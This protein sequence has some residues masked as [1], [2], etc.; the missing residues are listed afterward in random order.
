MDLAAMLISGLVAGLAAGAA[1]CA[2]V[3]GGFL[4]ALHPAGARVLATFL[5]A[6]V[7]AHAVVGA[8]LGLVGGALPMSPAVRAAV[9]VVAGVVICAHAVRRLRRGPSCAAR[10]EKGTSRAAALGAATVLTPCGVTLSVELVAVSSRSA[11][12]GA[13]LLGGFALGTAP[14]LAALGLVVR[15]AARFAA[16]AGLV[17]GVVTVGAGLRLGG[18]LPELSSSAAAAQTVMGADRVQRITVWATDRGFRPGVVAVQAGDPVEIT[19]R[20]AGNRGCTRT[21]AIA[22]RDV[23]LPETGAVTV[24]VPGAD[25][26]YACGMGMYVGYLEIAHEPRNGRSPPGPAAL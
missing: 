19:F 24:R 9:L 11:A 25:L 23:A 14:V 4:I 2:A 10:A 16:I 12:S 7:G 21:V 20:T 3:Q 13:V 5:G 1:S 15:V 8:V 18:W 22:G 6:R 17:A 26:R